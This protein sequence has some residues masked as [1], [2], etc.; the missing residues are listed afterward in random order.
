MFIRFH[1]P[2]HNWIAS[3]QRLFTASSLESLSR[4]NS[5]V[6]LYNPNSSCS[7][8]PVRVAITINISSYLAPSCQHGLVLPVRSNFRLACYS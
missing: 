2:K 4:G 7:G 3:R 5:D 1:L 6:S 8:L